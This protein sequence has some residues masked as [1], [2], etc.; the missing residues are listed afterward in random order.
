[1]GKMDIKRSNW[2]KKRKRTKKT[3]G[4]LGVLPRLVVFKS[5]KHIYAQL[6]DDISSKT[7]VSSSTKDKDML[8]VLKKVKG[9]INQSI[10]V[11]KIL[12][13][14]IKKS[15]IEKIVFDRNGY[16]YHGRVKALADA[17]RENGIKI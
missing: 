14:K 2:L 12:S 3:L 9:K 17:I 16:R 15:K 13:D 8:S 6:V 10:E 11:G 7:I 4:T 5:N 1:M